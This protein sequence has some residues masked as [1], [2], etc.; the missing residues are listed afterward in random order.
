MGRARCNAQGPVGRKAEDRESDNRDGL[1][2]NDD[3]AQKSQ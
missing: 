1:I 3:L 2:G